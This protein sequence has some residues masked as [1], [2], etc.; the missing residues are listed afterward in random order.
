MG[1]DSYSFTKEHWNNNAKCNYTKLFRIC[2]MGGK[3]KEHYYI[4]SEYSKESSSS[5]TYALCKLE[6]CIHCKGQR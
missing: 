6:K 1:R 2:S 4:C 5:S 3:N